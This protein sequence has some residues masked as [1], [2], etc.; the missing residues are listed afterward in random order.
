MKKAEDGNG[1][2]VRF[3]ETEGKYAKAKLSGFKPFSKVTLTNML[4]YDEKS[5]SVN[6]D[7]S[8]DVSVKPYEI[9]TIRIK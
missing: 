8:V 3:Y 6:A 7:G 4:E 9:I 5:L 2:I 1:S